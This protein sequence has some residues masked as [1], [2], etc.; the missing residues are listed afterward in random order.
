[1]IFCFFHTKRFSPPLCRFFIFVCQKVSFFFAINFQMGIIKLRSADGELVETTMDVATLSGTLKDLLEMGMATEDEETPLPNVNASILR[2]VLEW[3][4]HH[5]NDTPPGEEDNEN[6]KEAGDI[7]QWD[8]DFLS[9]DDGAL[10]EIILAANY[11]NVKGLLEVSTKTLA[12]KMKGKTPEEIR[13]E[14]NIENDFSEEE[15]AQMRK[16]K[17][18]CDDKP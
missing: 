5:M 18:W 2:K 15:K 1:M 4:E 10:F 8:A 16:E 17:E 9:I 7:P 13:A 3:A 14:F 12:L 11:L 6:E